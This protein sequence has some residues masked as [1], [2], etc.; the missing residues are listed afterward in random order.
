MPEQKIQR[1]FFIDGY[2]AHTFG[3]QDAQEYHDS[4]L[5]S[6]PGQ[7]QF[8][9]DVADTGVFLA[10]P[11]AGS[12]SGQHDWVVDHVVKDLGPVIRQKL[13]TPKKP[14][15]KLR[16][17][18][19]E[20][21]H[22][23]IFFIHKNGRGLGLRL[24][25]AAGG[26]CMCLLGAE[27]AAPVGSSAHAQI[28]INVS[29][30]FGVHNPEPMVTVC[31]P[32]WCGY[33]H[34]DWNE[35]ISIQKQTQPRER[36]S[37]EKFAMHVARK[38]LKFMEVFLIL[39]PD[40]LQETDVRIYQIAKNKTDDSDQSPQRYHIGDKHIAPQDVVLIGTVQVSHGSWMPILQLN[41]GYVQCLEN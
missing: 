9:A 35:Q 5:G 4:L 30:N 14:S 24:K 13:W 21:L 10:T 31:P 1:D 37:L 18:D 39:L 38:T 36:I 22:P 26:D 34:L 40:V 3:P 33:V 12:T 29:S 6:E 27:E 41:N 11:P 7:I 2:I 15:D 16:W 19:H 23:S 28:R 17:V 32:Q 20:Q 8:Q 25:E